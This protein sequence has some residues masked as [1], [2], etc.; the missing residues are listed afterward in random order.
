MNAP[1][2]TPEAVSIPPN[3]SPA[4][5]DSA[6]PILPRRSRVTPSALPISNRLRPAYPRGQR[7]ARAV[8]AQKR[9][10]PVPGTILVR[11]GAIDL[12]KTAAAAK[13]N[14]NPIWRSASPLTITRM[15]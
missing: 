13:M 2:A 6:R 11:C 8:Q 3:L 14:G 4:S 1:I 10:Q 7:L 9:H 15:R 5:T 12:V